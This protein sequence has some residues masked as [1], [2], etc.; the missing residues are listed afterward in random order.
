MSHLFQSFW[1]GDA[2]SP[3]ENLCLKSFVDH[4]H[5]LHLYSYDPDL[6]VPP[7]VVLRDAGEIAPAE[8][9]F[10][11]GHGPGQGS[12]AAFANLFRYELLLRHGQWWVDTDVVC[13]SGTIPESAAFFALEVPGRVNCA[14]LRFDAGHPVMRD[15]R[16]AAHRLGD[17]VAWGETGPAMVTAMLAR[18]GLLDH[19]APAATCYPFDWNAVWRLFDPAEAA[20]LRQATAPAFAM[21]L[22]HEI[23]RR[24]GI[25]KWTG[26]PEGCFLDALFTRH[27][28]GFPDRPRYGAAAIRQ[29]DRNR[30]GLEAI[31]GLTE[32]AARLRLA[33]AEA[34]A[35]AAE[36]AAEAAAAIASL[37]A[38]GADLRNALDGAEADIAGLRSVLGTAEL[39]AA[40]A[41]SRDRLA[42]MEASL[43][44]R[45]ARR[46]RHGLDR[47][48]LG[49]LATA[50]RL[51][52]PGPDARS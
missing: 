7:G 23:I 6:Q 37:S 8:A 26:V 21:H 17:G 15:C 40:A 18:H 19:A 9:I 47:A 31:E 29:L 46:L 38:E 45:L 24:A 10:H 51:A 49:R 20:A 35:V 16:D 22:W 32:E 3:Y 12:V 4:G 34:M 14:V 52:R 50:L 28:I 33:L 41:T 30:Q 27:G 1:H 36:D 42:A 39:E 44:W 48:G 43:S 11:Y 5:S 2:L 13:L 25:H